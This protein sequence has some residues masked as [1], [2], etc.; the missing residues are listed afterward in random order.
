M[1]D[2]EFWLKA[3]IAANIFLISAAL[4]FIIVPETTLLQEFDEYRSRLRANPQ[5]GAE[6][7][8]NALEF[9]G[10]V[11]YF[12]GLNGLRKFQRNARIHFSFGLIVLLTGRAAEG[13]DSLDM[14]T[15]FG[16]CLALSIVTSG[17]II[18]L[19]YFS[20]LNAKFAF[21]GEKALTGAI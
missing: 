4:F 20:S 15:P 2:L 12:A 8:K 9:L 19:I 16:A 14:S 21:D 18:G 10:A 6:R 3:S 17:L 13:A 5:A 1:R 11:F 7:L